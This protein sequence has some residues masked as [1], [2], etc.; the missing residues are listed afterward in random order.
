MQACPSLAV[1]NDSQVSI[2]KARLWYWTYTQNGAYYMHFVMRD[3]DACKTQ[4]SQHIKNLV[5][6]DMMETDKVRVAE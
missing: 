4:V 3:E 5:T 6:P 1:L 2:Q